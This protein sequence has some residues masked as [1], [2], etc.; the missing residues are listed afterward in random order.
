MNNNEIL[1]KYFIWEEKNSTDHQKN[2][3]NKN[4][5][6]INDTMT[7]TKTDST[8]IDWRNITEPKLRTKMRRRAWEKDNK[9]K[10]RLR[11]TQYYKNNDL[12]W[13]K[14]QEYIKTW[15]NNKRKND[16][17]YKLSCSL[18]E[19]VSRLVRTGSAVKDLGCTVEELKSYLESKFQYGMNWDNYGLYGWHIDHIIPLS[20]YDLT[21]RKQFLEACHYTNLQP[22]WAKDNLSKHNKIELATNLSAD[23]Q[24]IQ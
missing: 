11:K 12:A 3:E 2:Y 21:N 22:L 17:N 24:P 10:I 16:I 23:S 1:N 15:K 18:R 5:S 14:R 19:R 13:N 4:V 9:D 8:Q 7:N 20:S 6:E